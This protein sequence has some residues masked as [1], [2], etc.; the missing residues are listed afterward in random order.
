M[1]T[2]PIYRIGASQAGM[3]S[4]ES[5]GL[6]LPKADPVD[7]ATYVENGE[8]DLVGQGWLVCFWR[9]AELTVQQVATLEA[10]L[11]ECYIQTLEDDDTYGIY[12]AFFVREPKKAPK[13]G[14]I[15]D[16]VAEFRKL[17]AVT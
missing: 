8:G 3:Q 2:F 7:Y 15:H 6:P 4:L 14:R 9:F 13:V 10:Y 5:L 12:S 1:S 16:Y 11:G 17:T